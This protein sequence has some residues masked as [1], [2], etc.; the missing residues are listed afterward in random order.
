MFQVMFKVHRGISISLPHG[1]TLSMIPSLF[2][3]ESASGNRI[4]MGGKMWVRNGAGE[5]E[6]AR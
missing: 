6:W 2:S 4:W 5:L 1:W 3:V